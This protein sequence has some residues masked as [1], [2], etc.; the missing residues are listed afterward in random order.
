[1]SLIYDNATGD[2]LFQ[3]PKNYVNLNYTPANVTPT[4]ADIVLYG[5]ANYTVFGGLNNQPEGA[6]VFSPGANVTFAD[7][8]QPTPQGFT[9]GS[10]LQPYGSNVTFDAQ[11]SA[12]NVLI[13]RGATLTLN[14]IPNPLQPSTASDAFSNLWNEGGTLDI[15]GVNLQ[16]GGPG[17]LQTG[18]FTPGETEVHSGINQW[19]WLGNVTQGSTVAPLDFNLLNTIYPGPGAA[20][21]NGSLI[22]VGDGG[23]TPHVASSVSLGKAGLPNEEQ[24]VGNVAVNTSTLGGHW[25]QLSFKGA[26][27]VIAT[28]GIWDNVVKA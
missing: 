26:S 5:A 2:N 19:I 11:V 28:T 25:E 21:E 1:M 22:G 10:L 20:P 14:G 16:L 3:D 23:F 7:A 18:G 8:I 12:G 27:G 6:G 17:F 13:G 9:F 24:A 15:N 4:A